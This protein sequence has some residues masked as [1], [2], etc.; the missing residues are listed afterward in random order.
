LVTIAEKRHLLIDMALKRQRPGSGS[1]PEFLR[2]RTMR[3]QFPE[4]TSTLS[5][6]PWAATGAAAARMYMP[7]R[8]TNDLDILVSKKNATKV[9]RRLEQA[10]SVFKGTLS[11]GGTSWLLAD[12]FPLDIIESTDGWVESALKAAATNLDPQG[13]PV[14]PIQ[15]QVLMKFQASRVQDLADISRM[16]GQATAEQLQST[17]QLFAIQLPKDLD[18]LESLIALGRL[19][20]EGG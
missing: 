7:E 16:L 11:V 2:K 12:G 20:L 19:E 9:H 13:M 17:R 14:L 3:I 1:Q 15:Y 5:G 10:N 18:D 8:M 4:L 6:I